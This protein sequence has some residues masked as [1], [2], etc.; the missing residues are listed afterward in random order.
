MKKILKVDKPHP[1]PSDLQN[2]PRQSKFRS[3]IYKT[4]IIK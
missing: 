1:L 4:L 3:I 2:Y